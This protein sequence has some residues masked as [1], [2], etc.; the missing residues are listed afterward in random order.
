MLSVIIITKN[1][2]LSIERCIRSVAWA[3]EIIVVDSGSTDETV[4][5]CRSLGATVFETLDWPG[6]GPQKQRALDKATQPWVL[7]LDADEYISDDLKQQILAS[8][9]NEQINGYEIPRLSSYC[10]KNIQHGGWWPDYVTRLFKREHGHFSV[11]VVHEKIIVNGL[12]QKLD[13]PILHETYVNLE[14]VINK[15]NQYS[16]LGAE[17]LDAQNKTSSI[18]HALFRGL[19][20]FFRCYVLKKAFLD[21]AEGL[22]LAISNAEASYYKYAK[23]YLLNKRIR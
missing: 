20:T 16:S 22:M 3:S 15:V 7:S 13:S 19:W 8:I 17:K 10:G 9:T 4:D 12:T 14:E 11:D 6:F 18:V 21:G 1:E 23:L 5:I 2:A